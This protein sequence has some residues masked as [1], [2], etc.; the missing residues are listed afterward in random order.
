MAAARAYNVAL[1]GEGSGGE[2]SGSED[3]YAI[4][5]PAFKR[6]RIRA[7]LDSDDESGDDGSGVLAPEGA[8]V[9]V[10]D[11]ASQEA[12][13]S[14]IAP[15]TSDEVGDDGS[16]VLAPEGAGIDVKDRASQE[17][18]ES[19]IAPPT[20]DEE[21]DAILDIDLDVKD[22]VGDEE[23]FPSPDDDPTADD[24]DICDEVNTK[25]VDISRFSTVF[26]EI[27]RGLLT[28]LVEMAKKENVMA[29]DNDAR[30][31]TLG[32]WNLL[33]RVSV[34]Y[35]MKI[36]LPAIPFEVQM[37]FEKDTWSLEDFLCLPLPE[38][39]TRRGIY[40]N[41]ATSASQ[42]NALYNAYVGSALNLKKRISTHKLIAE[43]Y[44]VSDLPDSYKRSLHYTQVCREGI[45]VNFRRL[46]AFEYP[47]QRGY[48]LLLEG[49]FM[50]L[51]N[52]YRHPG[53]TS[54]W[55]T[56]S[57]YDMVNKVR[58]SLDIPAL[59]WSGMNA[60]WPL[61]QGF[62][63]E[64]AKL[65][66][67]CCNPA[68]TQ[69]TYP[70]SAF[71]E[72][73]KRYCRQTGEPGNPLGPYLCGVCFRYQ[74]AHGNLPDVDVLEKV[75][76][77]LETRAAAGS[78]AACDTCGRLESQL[79]G[80]SRTTSAGN[81]FSYGRKFRIHEGLP[82]RFLCEACWT[83][84]DQNGRQRTEEEVAQ[85]LLKTNLA[86]ER[87]AGRLIACN[88]CGAIE[89]SPTCK[90]KHHANE[91]AGVVLCQAC[92]GYLRAQKGPLSQKRMR[93]PNMQR[94]A[95]ARYRLQQIRQAGGTVTCVHCSKQEEPGKR[96]FTFGKESM[97]PVCRNCYDKKGR[98]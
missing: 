58:E 31:I 25:S 93:D 72:G 84:F 95:E 86:V 8:G 85:F 57:S 35:L 43:K 37:L 34:E 62:F 40:C 20:S 50:I 41:V 22:E 71:P 16:G 73:E 83:F 96:L 60:A 79:T 14:R 1:G 69:M 11:R 3:G 75:K 90:G 63:N 29:M 87:A 33:G 82:N 30:P 47:V 27:L 42:P 4:P 23:Y 44:S 21:I 48:L 80:R 94:H 74:S 10:K 66:S 51:F 78:D 67:M 55:A 54:K 36:F 98:R 26:L 39:D 64:S 92:D 53:Y 61:R 9:D 6:R 52:T 65:P 7:I 45:E 28:V 56:G 68:C 70:L 89:G 59:S 18:T 12:T 81:T 77:R 97:G 76:R 17:A 46:A 49:V 15:P 24:E 5:A 88:N 32:Y 91:E 2:R 19:R 13:E 38:D